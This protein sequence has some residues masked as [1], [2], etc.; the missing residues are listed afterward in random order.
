MYIK[1]ENI[2]LYFLL[3]NLINEMKYKVIVW[4]IACFLVDIVGVSMTII[5]VSGSR[6]MFI[7]C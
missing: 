1:I 3:I 7:W 4:Y 5:K 2:L 6:C